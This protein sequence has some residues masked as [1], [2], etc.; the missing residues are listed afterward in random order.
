M[1]ERKAIL[2]SE[3]FL[4]TKNKLISNAT[5]YNE[6]DSHIYEIESKL[7][8]TKSNMNKGIYHFILGKAY[9]DK[10]NYNE[11]IKNI[12]EGN[13]IIRKEIKYKVEEHI[14]SIKKVFIK[15]STLSIS[16]SRL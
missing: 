6:D 15:L 4:K 8:T 14:Q 1:Q 11:S 7:E 5:D 2:T 12:I 10:S 3:L 9:E 13:K 16:K